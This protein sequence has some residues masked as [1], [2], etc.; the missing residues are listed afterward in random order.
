MPPKE[1]E[2]HDRIKRIEQN[3]ASLGKWRWV[4]DYKVTMLIRIVGGG[5]ATILLGFL[6]AI[7]AL[8]WRSSP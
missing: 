4:M 7:I 5:I 6:S 3:L 8:V 1:D 2:T